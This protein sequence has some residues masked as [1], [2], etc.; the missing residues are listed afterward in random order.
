MKYIIF[1][2]P[3]FLKMFQNDMLASQDKGLMF[4]GGP[5]AG[6]PLDKPPGLP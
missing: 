2:F 5:L 4:S 3:N 1:L 6:N